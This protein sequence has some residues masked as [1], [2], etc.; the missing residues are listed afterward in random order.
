MTMQ[1]R[2]ETEPRHEN[3][4]KILETRIN[5]ANA[6]DQNQF[7]YP[8]QFDVEESEIYAHVMQG[9]NTV[10]WAKAMEKKLDKFC[11]NKT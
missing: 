11:K 8:T 4:L 2:E 6:V 9:P 1:T 10:K 7:V 5:L 3:H